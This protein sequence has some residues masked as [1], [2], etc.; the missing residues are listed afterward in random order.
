MS[1]FSKIYLSWRR[2]PGERRVL[3]GVIEK[4]ATSYIFEYL[5][6]NIKEAEKQGFTAYTEF[7][8]LKKKYTDQVLEIFAQRLMKAE[9]PDIQKFYSF[10]EV[11]ANHLSDKF[12][13]LGQTQAKQPTDNFELLADF[14][15]TPAV[16]FVTDLAGLSAEKISPEILSEGDELSFKL[17]SSNEYDQKPAVKVYKGDK[18]LGY[19]KKV[20]CNIF[21]QNGGERLKLKVKAVN[22]NGVLKQVFLRVTS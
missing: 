14:Q 11:D 13:L 8:D 9:R 3:V 2:G 7:P 1:D 18:L 21:H 22:K 19:I 4:S 6:E 12:Y 16:N 17:E 20:H 10:W 15:M 5:A